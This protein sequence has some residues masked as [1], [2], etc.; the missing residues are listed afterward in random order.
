MRHRTCW[1]GPW[2]ETPMPLYEFVCENCGPFEER[3][4]YSAASSPAWCPRCQ[5]PARRSYTP[6]HLYRTARAYR[7]A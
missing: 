4:P 6:P 3:R 2:G 1:E 7:Q 5:S